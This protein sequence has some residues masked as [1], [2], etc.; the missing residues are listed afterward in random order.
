MEDCYNPPRLC[1]ESLVEEMITKSYDYDGS[2]E[3]E[4]MLEDIVWPGEG[5]FSVW[6][7][8]DIV[9]TTDYFGECDMDIEPDICEITPAHTRDMEIVTGYTC[10]DKPQPDNKIA[11]MFKFT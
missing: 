5:Y 10:Y 8:G 2:E 1:H 9:W 6:I 11:G 4:F 7:V 3:R